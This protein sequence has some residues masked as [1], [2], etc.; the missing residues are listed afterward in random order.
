MSAGTSSL[1]LTR[2][3]QQ[4]AHLATYDLVV[5]GVTYNLSP[6]SSNSAT[7]TTNS[8]VGSNG[9]T[10]VSLFL[11]ENT[12]NA[13]IANA[14]LTTGSTKDELFGIVGNATSTSTL[15]S[16]ANATYS[17]IGEISIDKT[18]GQFDDAPGTSSMSVDFTGGTLT[19]S[20][21]VSDAAG[22]NGG[23][24]DVAGSATLP[25]TGTVSGN[26]FSAT[27][28]Y[29]NLIAVTNGVSS[30]TGQPVIGGFYGPN[31]ENAVGV[32]LSLG[33]SSV[34]NDVI[35]YT[36]IQATKQ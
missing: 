36:R 34:A 13:S 7:S 15:A 4:A 20:F 27:V 29:T 24:L 16:I 32:G 12:A 2:T 17:G 31:A 21:S 35:V 25:M 19:G 26:T 1:T 28:D 6:A 3:N 8:F 11:N 23:A 5:N 10:S 18:N 9:G 30:I 22:D 33:Q 14:Q